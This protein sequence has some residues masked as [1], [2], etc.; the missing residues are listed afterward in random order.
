MSRP[1]IK[2]NVW[3]DPQNGPYEPPRLK[4]L[5]ET[6]LKKRTED[7]PMEGTLYLFLGF[8]ITW[9]ILFIY[10]FSMVKKQKK[11]EIQLDKI[12]SILAG[13]DDDT[14]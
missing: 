2:R 8:S 5:L 7:K 10:I 11:L 13:P 14:K 1:F 12:K 9:I 4:R 6:V 3:N